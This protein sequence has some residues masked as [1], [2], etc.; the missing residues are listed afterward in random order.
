MRRFLAALLVAAFPA[1]AT[2]AEVTHDAEIELR[3]ADGAITVVDRIA[4][5][6]GQWDT[7]NLNKRM[8]GVTIEVD[9]A[10]LQAPP[11][12]STWPLPKGAK[13]VTVRYGGLAAEIAPQPIEDRTG[14]GADD[15]VITADGTFLPSWS[16]WLPDVGAEQ[17][18]FRLKVTAPAGTVAVAT[19]KLIEESTGDGRYA[20]TFVS[21]ADESPSLFAGPYKVIERH[22][23]TLLLR[24]YFHAELSDALADEYLQFSTGIIDRYA[25]Q[26]GPYPFAA[27]HIVSAPLPVGLGFPGLTYIDRRILPLPF[28]RSQSLAHEI[29]HNWWGNGVAP[30]YVRGNWSEG[31][32][33]FQ[34]DYGLA[35]PERQRAMRLDWLRD[36]AALPAERDTPPIAFHG[37]GHDAS[38]VVGY[39]KVAFFFHMLR[40]EIGAKAFDAGLRRIWERYRLKTAGWSDLRSAF[41][42]TSGRDLRRFFIQWLER[43][44]APA[45]AVA[46]TKATQDNGRWRVELRLTQAEPGYALTVPVAVETASGRQIFRIAMDGPQGKGSFVVMERPLAVAVDP[47]HELFRRLAPGEAPPILRDVTLASEAGIVILAEGEAGETAR[48]L[49]RRLLDRDGS[50]VAPAAAAGHVGPLI[51]VGLADQVAQLLPQLG[52]EQNDG[53]EASGAARV[54]VSRRDRGPVLVVAA[55]DQAALKALSRPLPH[56]G[57]ESFLVFDGAKVLRKGLWPAGDNPLRRPL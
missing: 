42:Q 49:A 19:G 44:G 46:E 32:T 15:A 16:N 11:Q 55:V 52:L 7:V 34:A 20:A 47:D 53:P 43:P 13:T 5:P 41:E 37:K 56:Y 30:D 50:E 21:E 8:T 6:P 26:I 18:S 4:L 40:D 36:Y 39:N 3:P 22:H 28:I 33:T 29:L 35:D 25:G 14:G 57:R 9:G 54:W 24:A 31:L 48:A 2:A 51:V 23:G 27:F 45:L 1:A 10:P 38:Q 12:G 17:E